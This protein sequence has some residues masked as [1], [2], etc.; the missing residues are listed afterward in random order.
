MLIISYLCIAG[1]YIFVDRYHLF[2]RQFLRLLRRT[3][4]APKPAFKDRFSAGNCSGQATRN[5]RRGH[6]LLQD[7]FDWE[8]PFCPSLSRSKL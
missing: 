6:I 1:F 5:R 2:R 7:H 8:F 3:T 4:V